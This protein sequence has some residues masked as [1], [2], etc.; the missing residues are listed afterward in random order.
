MRLAGSIA[1]AVS[2]PLLI[3]SLGLSS[4]VV[5]APPARAADLAIPVSCD[6]PVT[7]TQDNLSYELVGTCGVVRIT[8]SNVD[9]RMPAATR[10]VVAGDHNTVHAKPV[11]ELRVRG[12][13]QDVY[14]ISTVDAAVSS[15][16]SRVRIGG[17][18]ETV[19][20]TGNGAHF[21]ADRV[22]ALFVPGNRNRVSSGRAYDASVGGNGN[23]ITW[24]RLEELRVGG[25]RNVLRVRRGST[26]ARVWGHRNELH[27][28]RA[29]QP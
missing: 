13:D 16:A 10:L 20:L 1:I 11:R 3:A 24:R 23:T 29:V 17:L 6:E 26:D 12:H 5:A 21:V 22:N 27:L 2:A 25:D 9:V 8:A 15:P 7:I 28:H 19:H 14:V 4:A 18:A